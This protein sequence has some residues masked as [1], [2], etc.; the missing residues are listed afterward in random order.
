M[1]VLAQSWNTYE[2]V[3]PQHVYVATC[4]RRILLMTVLFVDLQTQ[5][6]CDQIVL[7]LK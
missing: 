7:L 3:L 5:N 2:I 6:K 4:E 1:V